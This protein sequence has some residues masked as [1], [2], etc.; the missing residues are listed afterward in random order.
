MVNPAGDPR[1]LLALG[2]NRQGAWG[3]PRG[4]LTRALN[5]LQA[6]GVA[7][8]RI[9]HL[10]RTSPVGSGRQPSYLNA[11]AVATSALGPTS[12][13]RLL[14]QLERRAGRRVTPPLQPRPLDIDILD[15]GG[16]R[17]NW[18]APGRKRGGLVLPHPLLHQRAFVLVP[19]LEVAPHWSHPVLAVRVR[20][21]LARLGAKGMRGVHRLNR[22]PLPEH[23]A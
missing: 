9:S 14:K 8:V 10:Y 7:I 13:L 15:L 12:L 22:L 11:V 1:L 4:S 18:P 20:T 16:R 5:E 3:G 6:A 23:C 19:L 17:L 2:A 21:L